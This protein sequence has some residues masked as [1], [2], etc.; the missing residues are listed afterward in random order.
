MFVFRIILN[1]ITQVH[2]SVISA[3]QR[4][5]TSK[6]SAATSSRTLMRQ[7]ACVEAQSLVSR[8]PPCVLIVEPS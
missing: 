8:P 6:H 4:C 5:Q 3:M 7:G 2:F 1:T